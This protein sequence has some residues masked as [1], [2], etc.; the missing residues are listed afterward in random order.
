MAAYVRAIR[1][2]PAASTS[3][4]WKR[5]SCSTTWCQPAAGPSASMSSTALVA[6]AGT[7]PT[8]AIS[9]IASSSI[10]RRIRKTSLTSA[11]VSTGTCTPRWASC[12]SRPSDT[13]WR[14][15]ARR[16]WRE[17]PSSADVCSSGRRAPGPS[18]PSRIR[19]R[20]IDAA[21]SIVEV[22]P[23]AGDCSTIL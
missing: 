13:S 16:V 21:E 19:L 3:A 4:R 5:M 1:G 2:L 12:R 10:M 18:A 15:A 8:S 22:P 17:T 9:S 7:L 14:R 20:M 11:G 23:T 6:P